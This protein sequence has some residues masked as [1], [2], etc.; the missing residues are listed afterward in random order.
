MNVAD[1]LRLVTISLVL[2]IALALSRD[3]SAALISLDND[4]EISWADIPCPVNPGL[5]VDPILVFGAPTLIEDAALVGDLITIQVDFLGVTLEKILT[6]PGAPTST[7]LIVNVGDSS[8]NQVNE[9]GTDT[10]LQLTYLVSPS[11]FNTE[12]SDLLLTLSQ[13][14][15]FDLLPEGDLFFTI[16]FKPRLSLFDRSPERPDQA[17]IITMS[18]PVGVPEPGTLALFVCGLA[19]VRCVR[20][21]RTVRI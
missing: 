13:F 14:Q 17:V 5:C 4:V 21:R 10:P 2:L 3:A 15:N 7:P 1:R 12:A 8:F 16:A 20:Q 19:G 18:A 9:P 6:F 11:G